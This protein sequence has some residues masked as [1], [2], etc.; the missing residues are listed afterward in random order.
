MNKDFQRSEN[1][2][3]FSKNPYYFQILLKWFLDFESSNRFVKKIWK[4]KRETGQIA[5]QKMTGGS[6]NQKSFLTRSYASR[7]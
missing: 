2:E 3:F 1:W 4:N 7:F 6:L 5:V